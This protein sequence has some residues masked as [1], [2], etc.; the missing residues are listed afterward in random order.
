MDNGYNNYYTLHDMKYGQRIYEVY[1]VGGSWLTVRSAAYHQY[2]VEGLSTAFSSRRQ[3][4]TSD[5]FKGS[6]RGLS[7]RSLT[8]EFLDQDYI[9][10]MY[11]VQCLEGET[12]DFTLND[13]GYKVNTEL[14]E[15]VK[16]TGYFSIKSLE[17]CEAG[18]NALGKN[19]SGDNKFYTANYIG[20]ENG[21]CR[22]VSSCSKCNINNASLFG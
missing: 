15:V 6:G 19:N 18:I 8:V 4:L 10:L 9:A 14:C 1:P 22:K 12:P 5:F 16:H 13:I 20:D 17:G 7:A 21:I 2:K 3:D 11:A